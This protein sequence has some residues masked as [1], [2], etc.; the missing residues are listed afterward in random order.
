MKTL[1]KIL[2]L[3]VLWI[4]CESSTEP[5][6]V[7]GCTDET[8]CNYNIDATEDNETC[9]YPED[10]CDCNDVCPHLI[11]NRICITPDESEMIE[12]YNPLNESVDLSNYYLSD[13]DTT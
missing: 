8:A 1:I 4:S 3:S 13:S 7:Y 5:E 2:C 6:D 12:I 9:I 11:F 10:G